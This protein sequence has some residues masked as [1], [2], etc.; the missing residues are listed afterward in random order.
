MIWRLHLLPGAE[1]KLNKLP[2][3]D[4]QRIKDEL[5]A[6]A[7]EPYPRLYDQKTERTSE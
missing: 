3:L 4:A 2:D 7:D 5:D 1:R 6:L